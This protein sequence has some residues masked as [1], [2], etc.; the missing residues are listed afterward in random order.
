MGWPLKFLNSLVPLAMG[1]NRLAQQMPRRC[2][3]MFS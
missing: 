3:N 1:E 2:C